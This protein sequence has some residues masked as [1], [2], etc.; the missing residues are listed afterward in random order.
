MKLALPY[1]E[2]QVNQHFGRS[3][4]FTIVDVEGGV[5]KDK[6]NVSAVNLQHNHEGLAGLMLTEDVDVVITGG[7]GAHALSSL[8]GAGLKVITG[9]GGSIDEVVNSYMRGE[10]VS[11]RAACNHHDGKH[12]GQGCHHN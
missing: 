1:E 6:K 10:L 4:E 8:E 12:H 5:I 11:R 9:A 3:R 2:G 7:I